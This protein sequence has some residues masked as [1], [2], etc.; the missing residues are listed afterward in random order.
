M[1]KKLISIL[2]AAIV[3]V[4][5]C[6]C[7]GGGQKEASEDKEFVTLGDAFAADS[8]TEMSA[9]DDKNFVYV[10][11]YQGK[12]LRVSAELTKE[13][14]EAIDE[15]D[16]ASE[17]GFD[18]IEKIVSDLEITKTEDLSA[19]MLSD[20]EL[21]AYTGMTGAKLLEDGFSESGWSIYDDVTEVYYIK[22]LYQYK[23][24][25]DQNI[26]EDSIDDDFDAAEAV[27]DFTIKAIEYED[28]S[29]NC[30]DLSIVP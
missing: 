26:D 16:F 22:G 13:K 1:K 18:E 29:Y 9:Y 7:S 4:S 20:D 24:T 15:V 17:N 21:S 11:E 14:L 19:G 2:L 30:T 23:A 8:E 12:I 10:F 5:L 27:S 28:L 6:A 3:A 25:F